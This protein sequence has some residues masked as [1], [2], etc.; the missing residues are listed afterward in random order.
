MLFTF[1][2]QYLRENKIFPKYFNRSV[3]VLIVIFNYV[4]SNK[5]GTGSPFKNR[6]PFRSVNDTISEII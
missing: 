6:F 1:Y 5:K 3:D 2:V 4:I